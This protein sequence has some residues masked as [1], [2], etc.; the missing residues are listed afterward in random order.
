MALTP[1][2]IKKQEF[3]KSFRGY[4]VSEVNAFLEKVSRDYSDLIQELKNS[5][6]KN[7]EIDIQLREYQKLE[8]TL[9]QTLI[10]AQE[11]STKTLEN[12]KKEGE[13]IIQE[14]EL[15]SGKILEDARTEILRRQEEVVILRAKKESITSRLKVL[16]SSELELINALEL[17][18]K[19]NSDT[20]LGTGKQYFNINEVLKKLS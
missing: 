6:Q 16:L 4:D 5:Q 8:K 10:Q 17:D 13:L 11:T 18:D 3:K 7:I 12:S 2:E 14:A 19:Q 20:S 9:Q 1:L 15:K